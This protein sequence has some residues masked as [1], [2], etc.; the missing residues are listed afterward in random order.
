MVGNGTTSGPIDGPTTTLD[1]CNGKVRS[2]GEGY[3][4]FITPNAPYSVGCFVGEVGLVVCDDAITS[5]T[6]GCPRRGI[7]NT[8]HNGTLGDASESSVDSTVL[9]LSPND[10]SCPVELVYY[11]GPLFTFPYPEPRLDGPEFRMLSQVAGYSFSLV[12]LMC[13]IFYLRGIKRDVFQG[14]REVLVVLTGFAAT[15]R[16]IFYLVDP[17]AI[18]GCIHPLLLGYIFGLVYPLLNNQLVYEN[19]FLCE[20]MVHYTKQSLKRAIK[21]E[22]E[23]DLNS[24]KSRTGGK[25]GSSKVVYNDEDEDRRKSGPVTTES[26]DLDSIGDWLFFSDIVDSARLDDD[27]YDQKSVDIDRKSVDRK[28]Q[29]ELAS[30]TVDFDSV[31]PDPAIAKAATRRSRNSSLRSVGSAR[32]VGSV[33]SARSVSGTAPL[34]CRTWRIAHCSSHNRGHPIRRPNSVL[35]TTTHTPLDAQLSPQDG[36][37]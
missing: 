7:N 32:S 22:S 29:T 17:F 21:S 26:V 20:I 10:K 15:L 16:A 3:G 14:P 25:E 1:Q 8:Y 4:Y 24:L 18:N 28:S 9:D 23:Y 31:Y 6:R 13:L 27:D 30:S 5:P 33:R 36:N 19:L 37:F 2:D 35:S 34:V 11:S 12:A